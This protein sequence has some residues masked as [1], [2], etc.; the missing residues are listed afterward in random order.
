MVNSEFGT[1]Q[2]R[3]FGLLVGGIFGLL[4]LL[5]ILFRGE[6]PRL[7]AVVLSGLLVIPALVLPKSLT[8]IYRAWMTLGYALGWINTRII[9]S[10]TFYGMF[11]PIGLTRRFLL[12]KDSLLRR[13]DPNIN[14]YRVNRQ[15]RPG[16]HMKR[17]F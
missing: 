16:S 6:D 10:V 9:L 7:W 12:G 17:Q 15:A 11:T 13:F 14:T 4:G 2:L 8:P 3:T 1:N 5:P